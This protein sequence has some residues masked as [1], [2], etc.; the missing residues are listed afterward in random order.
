M[1]ADRS[2][3]HWGIS[4]GNG[5][6][7]L[8]EDFSCRLDNFNSYASP[9]NLMVFEQIKEKSGQLM[10]YPAFDVERSEHHAF[11]TFVHQWIIDAIIESG[12]TC[13]ECG[14]YDKKLK[15]GYGGRIQNWKRTLCRPCW[16][17]HF[18]KKT[19]GGAHP[20]DVRKLLNLGLE[21]D[22]ER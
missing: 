17:K 13:E 8:I 1:P 11:P 21:I 19:W 10:I 14:V 5:W 3:M 22:E 18:K 12:H 7:K 2:C 6:F 16:K 20:D 15:P 4:T 9:L